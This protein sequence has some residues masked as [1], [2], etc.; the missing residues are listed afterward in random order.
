MKMLTLVVFLIAHV[1][2]VA[3]AGTAAVPENCKE[4]GAPQAIE[5]AYKDFS[6]SLASSSKAGSKGT[7]KDFLTD[8]DNYELRAVLERNNYIVKF[9]PHAYPGGVVKG[10][11]ATYTINRCTLVIEDVKGRQPIE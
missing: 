9:L 4:R 10:A 7:L 2:L 8:I 5:Q 1:P 3:V 6:A 11:G